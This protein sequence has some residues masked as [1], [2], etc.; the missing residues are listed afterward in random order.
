QVIGNFLSNAIKFT[1]KGMVEAALE[2]Q[3]REG[4]GDRV[5]FRV[6]DTGI[7]VTPEQQARLFQPFSQAEGSTTR[8]FGGTGLGLVISRRLAELMGGEVS[9]ESTP[10]AGTTLKLTL[11]V[12]RGEEAALEPELAPDPAQGFLARPLPG[13]EEARAEGSLVLI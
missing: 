11:V 5:C 6:T 9:M 12:P 8:R 10:G 13:V 2:W 7:G 1:E 3:G 4:D